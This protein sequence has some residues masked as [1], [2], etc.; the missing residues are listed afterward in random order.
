[1]PT[2][3]QSDNR[4]TFHQH[5][6]IPPAPAVCLYLISALDHIA[7]PGANAIWLTP[8]FDSPF[9]RYRKDDSEILVVIKTDPESDNKVAMIFSDRDAEVA[10]PGEE[11]LH[12]VRGYR[13][14][15]I[16]LQ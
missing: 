15:L 5:T 2:H 9:D 1:M 6:G 13:P 10:L 7:R 11:S 12:H 16:K 4:A 8:I 3:F 14:E